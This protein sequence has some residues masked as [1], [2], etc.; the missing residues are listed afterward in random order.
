MQMLPKR[1]VAKGRN[2]DRR[3]RDPEINQWNLNK[4]SMDHVEDEGCLGDGCPDRAL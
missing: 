4:L 1:N 3:E 2:G